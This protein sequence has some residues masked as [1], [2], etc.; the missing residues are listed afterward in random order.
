MLSLF[1]CLDPESKA[2]TLLKKV[3]AGEEEGLKRLRR[4]YGR[5]KRHNRIPH[6][7][8]GRR[9]KEHSKTLKRRRSTAPYS[10]KTK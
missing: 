3:R 9:K 6:G 4:K 8:E 7:N 1:A 10:P 2:R 5:L